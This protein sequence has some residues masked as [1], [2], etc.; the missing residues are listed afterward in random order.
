MTTRICF[1]CGSDTTRVRFTTFS[2]DKNGKQYRAEDW[3]K[4]ENGNRICNKCYRAKRSKR[5]MRFLG[6]KITLS[7]KIRKG[8]CSKCGNNIFDGSCKNTNM[9]H[10]FY[11][12][13]LV[14]FGTIELCASCHAEEE[15]KDRPLI[16][17]QHG[18]FKQKRRSV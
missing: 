14:W 3:Y 7:F 12:P 16:K 1:E 5:E 10:I 13:I 9:H 11:V 17:N 18:M 6:K 4:N 2:H 15:L 8:I